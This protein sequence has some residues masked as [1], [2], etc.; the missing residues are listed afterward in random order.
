[1]DDEHELLLQERCKALE[2]ALACQ[3]REAAIQ[4]TELT[5]LRQDHSAMV[6]KMKYME[7]L[8][9]TLYAE[10]CKVHILRQHDLE[11]FKAASLGTLGHTPWTKPL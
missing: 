9:E 3:Q 4:M 2:Q 11:H 6:D 8:C 5:T 1:M 10:I 7:Q